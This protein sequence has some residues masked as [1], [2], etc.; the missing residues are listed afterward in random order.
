ML[1]LYECMHRKLVLRNEAHERLRAAQM[2]PNF[3]ECH[4]LFL[5]FDGDVD[6]PLELVIGVILSLQI[7]ETFVMF[8]ENLQSELVIRLGRRLMNCLTFF[9]SWKSSMVLGTK[10]VSAIL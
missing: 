5:C 10:S 3:L 4:L 2:G 7:F 9:V 1:I 6:G 8:A